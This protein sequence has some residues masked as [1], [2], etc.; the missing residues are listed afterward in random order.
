MVQDLDL[1]VISSEPYLMFPIVREN[2]PNSCAVSTWILAESY[3]VLPLSSNI[4]V[5]TPEPTPTDGKFST[6][7]S[8]EPTYAVTLPSEFLHISSGEEYSLKLQAL[9]QIFIREQ[10]SDVFLIYDIMTGESRSPGIVR[11]PR[12]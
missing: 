8:A 5:S 2:I 10:W 7:C 6:M 4:T 12:K 3:D 9:S 11:C 1:V